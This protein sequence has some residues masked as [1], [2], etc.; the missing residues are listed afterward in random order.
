MLYWAESRD[1]AIV[2]SI[3]M[4]SFLRNFETIP[5]SMSLQKLGL[6]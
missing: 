6:K 3:R 1:W 2:K 4:K 5:F